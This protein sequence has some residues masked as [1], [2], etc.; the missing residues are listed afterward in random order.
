MVSTADCSIAA[1]T[2]SI[3]CGQLTTF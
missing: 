2:Y 1:S 3:Q